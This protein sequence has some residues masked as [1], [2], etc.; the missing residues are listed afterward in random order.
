M[1]SFVLTGGNLIPW[2]LRVPQVI[3]GIDFGS[4]TLRA[5]RVKFTPGFPEYA[6][7]FR[8]LPLIKYL[9]RQACRRMIPSA[10]APAPGPQPLLH[11]RL[12]LY[13]FPPWLALGAVIQYFCHPGVWCSFTCTDMSCPPQAPPPSLMVS[14]VR[15]YYGFLH[16]FALSS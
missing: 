4:C 7:S 5:H 16:G 8:R 12:H 3:T 6:E 11:F 10:A 14:S 13:L 1:E 2:V 15:D 9:A